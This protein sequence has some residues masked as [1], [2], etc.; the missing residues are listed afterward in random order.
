MHA[1]RN[2]ELD[3]AHHHYKSEG[4]E[5]EDSDTNRL[6]VAVNESLKEEIPS[7]LSIKSVNLK[8]LDLIGQGSN[9]MS[10]HQYNVFT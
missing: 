10:C 1:Y 8:V 4:H 2:E 5:S 7:S 9:W 3:I 6:H